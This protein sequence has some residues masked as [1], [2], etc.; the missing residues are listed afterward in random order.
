[1][2][3]YRTI[4]QQTDDKY[5]PP[6]APVLEVDVIGTDA[7]LSVSEYEE[8]AKTSTL[9]RLQTVCVPLRDLVRALDGD[10][11]FASPELRPDRTRS[12]A[13]SSEESSARG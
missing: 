6:D 11:F 5:A 9:T 2:S 3:M 10:W 13:E 12:S 7:F 4:I 8:N 1:M